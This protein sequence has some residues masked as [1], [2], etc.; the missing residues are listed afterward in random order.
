MPDP[1][2]TL[3]DPLRADRALGLDGAV[4]E[5]NVIQSVDPALDASTIAAVKT[6]RFEPATRCGKP[7][8]AKYKLARRFEL[9]D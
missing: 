4:V 9:R 6:W 3:V 2:V 8:E 5:V 1:D 7:I